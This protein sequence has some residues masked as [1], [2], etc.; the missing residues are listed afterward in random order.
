MGAH[1]YEL[2]NAEIEERSLRSVTGRANVARK[3]KPGHSGRDDRSS[4]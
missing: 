4:I 1:G 3:K 2:P